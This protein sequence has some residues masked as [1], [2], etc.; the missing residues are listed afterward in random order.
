MPLVRRRANF[1][2]VSPFERGR[3]IGMHE[4]GLTFREIGRRVG[5]PH[6]TI[7]RIWRDW[8]EETLEARRRG[9]G[10]P[11]A[12]QEREDR[13]LRRSAI[14]DPA[15]P[16]RAIAINWVR[17]IGHRVS[18]STIYRR[19]LSFGLR[20]YRP[21][22]RLP[23]TRQHKA[24]RLQWS[25]ERQNWDHEWEEIIFSDESRFCLHHSDGRVRI[26][27]P[28]G[29]RQNLDFAQ[30]RHT[31]LTPGVMVW[32]A[33]RYGGR[34]PLVFI[35]GTLNAQRYIET[36]L[37]PVLLPF[38]QHLPEAVF[39]QDNARPHTANITTGFLAENNV[40]CLPWPARSP[41][42]NPIEHVWDMM[43]R[44]LRRLPH[45]P[46]NLGELRQQLQIAWNELAQ[47]AID[48]LISSMS[49]RVAECVRVRGDAT[50]Y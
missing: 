9:S 3:I 47:D 18:M 44:R 6:T 41:D 27:R 29:Q 16:S 25:Q 30:R 46:N 32:G 50:H 17:A 45:P 10:R 49:R 11:R 36:I 38:I 26:R 37:E 4:A 43:D 2:Q 19:I 42:L 8:Q 13:L 35:P 1:H 14:Q 34:S 20:S 23:M 24:A 12:T 40:N 48:Q 31:A 5:R 28:R 15:E 33:I 39:Q 7:R 22:F 21:Y